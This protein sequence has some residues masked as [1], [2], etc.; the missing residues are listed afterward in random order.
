MCTCNSGSERRKQAYLGSVAKLMSSRFSKSPC[1]KKQSS[2]V[3]ED[4]NVDLQ[5]P[6]MHAWVHEFT[7]MLGEWGLAL[8]DGL[9]ECSLFQQGS[10]WNGS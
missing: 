8:V 4:T 6:Y 3:I 9:R 1:L 10:Q 7:A 2:N 5:L